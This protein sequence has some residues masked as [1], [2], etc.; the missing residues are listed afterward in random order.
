[1]AVQ[2]VKEVFR[3]LWQRNKVLH[4]HRFYDFAKRNQK[5]RCPFKILFGGACRQ[6]IFFLD[7]HFDRFCEAKSVKMAIQKNFLPPPK[8]AEHAS[9]T[10]KKGILPFALRG[11]YALT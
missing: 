8:A 7:R 11:R 6:I 3:C 9:H 5:K 10:L 1:L 2:A 4:G